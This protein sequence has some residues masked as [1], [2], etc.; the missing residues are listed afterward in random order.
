MEAVSLMWRAKTESGWQRFPVVI[1]R[2]GR[3]KKGAVLVNGAERNYPEGH[4]VLRYYENR[5]TRYTNVGT[6]ATEAINARDRLQNIQGARTA[7]AV[8]GVTI[9]EPEI[10]K[11]IKR[12]AERYVQSAE[13]RGAHEAAEVNRLALMEFQAANPRLRF[14][15]EITAE[16]LVCYWRFLKTN[17]RSDRTIRNKHSRV[18]GFLRFVGLNYRDWGLRAPRYEKKLPDIYTKEEIRRLRKACTRDYHRVLVALFSKTGMRDGEV[19]HLTWADVKLPESKIRVTSKP[20][21]SWHIKDYEQRDL[22]L[23]RDLEQL[24]RSWRKANPK[25]KL[26]LGTVNDQPNSKLLPML[27]GIAKRAGIES[28]T[29]HKFRRTYASVLLQH[30]VDLRT[31]QQLMGHN[32]LAS[33]MRYLTPATSDEVRA[34]INSILK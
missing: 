18:V 17:R 28:A 13:D 24:L 10:R 4:F 15:D 9:V 31:V 34:K 23:P 8:A 19:Q 1:G 30:G 27:K 33:T 6:D 16:S 26:V 12:E 25:K 5:K 2:N 20:E 21:Y 7:A 3:I 29:L 32:D 14:V 11:T 22:P